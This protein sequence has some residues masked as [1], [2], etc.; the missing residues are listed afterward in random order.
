M[1]ERGPRQGPGIPHPANRCHRGRERLSA[2]ERGKQSYR[3]FFGFQKEGGARSRIQDRFVEDL[4]I[5]P[6]ARKLGIRIHVYEN[7]LV[8][9]PWTVFN[10]QPGLEGVYMYNPS[11]GHYDALE[12]LDEWQADS[13]TASTS[14]TAARKRPMES[15]VD[16]RIKAVNRAG[17]ETG[18]ELT[19][20]N[21]AIDHFVQLR[22]KADD[23]ELLM[24]I[25]SEIVENL[26]R[27][28]IL[29]ERQIKNIKTK[30]SHVDEKSTLEKSL[31]TD[32][33]EVLQLTENQN[34]NRDL[35]LKLEAL[36][37]ETNEL[38]RH[39]KLDMQRET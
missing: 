35:A 1:F 20:V 5:G 25:D 17:T 31:G 8:A 14:L 28:K 38:I 18:T 6:L 3:L 39:A 11:N 33:F 37:S 24:W 7:K 23:D 4:E 32:H 36:L 26:T 30:I 27:R 22:S 21:S 13:S 2:Y 10:N 15:G 16:K 12:L 34:E 19:A 29:L 9:T